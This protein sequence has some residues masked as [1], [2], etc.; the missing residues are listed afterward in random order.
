[1]NVESI[2][3]IN[4][5]GLNKFEKKDFFDRNFKQIISFHKRK[6][7]LFKKLSSTLFNEY[8]KD[9][10]L[11]EYPFI[12]IRL[13]KDHDLKSIQSKDIY[14]VLYSSG[15]SG[16]L[17]KIF[18]DKNNSK[19]QVKALNRIASEFLGKERLPMLIIDKENIGS[20]KCP[21]SLKH[22]TVPAVDEIHNH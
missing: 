13:F 14:R 19:N 12:P 11:N 22:Y 21:H 17:S 2:L 3:D 16:S 5:F 8:N 9:S 6:S 18:L 1:M 20:L 7:K 15:T 10:K 4:P